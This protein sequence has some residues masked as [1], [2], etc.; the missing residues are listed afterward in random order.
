MFLSEIKFTYSLSKN[1]K[2]KV[3]RKHKLP[4]HSSSDFKAK[5]R[6]GQFATKAIYK[7]LPGKK[8]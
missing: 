3:V 5:N 7:G 6:C 1:D 4:S 8:V 2:N